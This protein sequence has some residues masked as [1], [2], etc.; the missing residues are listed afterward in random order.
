MSD[1]ISATAGSGAG[2][3][4]ILLKS[5]KF[6]ILSY[7]ISL[8]LLLVLAFVIVYTDISETI[9]GP[10]VNII[11]LS[12]AFISSLLTAKNLTSRGWLFGFVTGTFNIAFLFVAGTLFTSSAFFTVPRIMFMLYGGMCGAIGGII[13]VNVGKN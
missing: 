3:I 1:V 8:I 12:G 5:V 6:I 13:G 2:T 9:S 11:T 4:R 7:I 10:A